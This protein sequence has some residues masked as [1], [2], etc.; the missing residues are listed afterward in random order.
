MPDLTINLDDELYQRLQAWAH[1]QNQPL[2]ALARDII[3]AAE[4]AHAQFDR[5]TT[6]STR[7][8]RRHR[9]GGCGLCDA[10]EP[11]FAV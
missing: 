1:G 4:R 6:R 5:S 3:A 8:I 11:L 10:L 2:P 9:D 7:D